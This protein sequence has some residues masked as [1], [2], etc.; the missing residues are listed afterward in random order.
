MKAVK[1]LKAAAALLIFAVSAGSGYAGVVSAAVRFDAASS[2]VE[3]APA[4]AETAETSAEASKPQETVEKAPQE[5]EQE[6][7]KPAAETSVAEKTSSV[8]E[9]PQPPASPA[10]TGE[11]RAVWFSYIEF[12]EL[13][14]G[15]TKAEFTYNIRSCFDKCAAYGLNTVIVQVRSNADALYKSA[16]FPASEYITGKRSNSLQFDPLAIMTEEAHRRSLRIEAWIN[17]YRANRVTSEFADDDIVERWLGTDNVFELNGYYYLNPGEPQAR[18]LIIN[19]VTEIV[20]NYDIDGI[21]FDDYFYPSQSAE[22]DAVTFKKYGEGKTL[23][24]FRTASVNELISSVYREIKKRKSIVFG[25][26]PAGN[27]ENCLN[28]GADVRLWGSENGYVDYLAPQLYWDYGQGILPYEKALDEWKKAVVNPN[29][30]LLVGLAA[31]RAGDESLSPYWGSG[32]V[33]A[34]QVADARN[35]ANYK[36]FILF[37]YEHF[38]DDVRAAERSSLKSILN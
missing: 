21:H 14:T 10:V 27:I 15:K 28:A 18:L 24:E 37:R 19:G 3:P 6:I 22:I 30:K 25:I 26:S 23:S 1:I 2:L 32:N 29:V 36:G 20:E 16:F 13:L 38:F 8:Q 7:K 31:Y 9:K 34:R 5:A 12:A 4:P 11:L 35:A 17:P 33:L